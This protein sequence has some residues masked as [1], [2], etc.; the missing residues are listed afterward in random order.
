MQMP[1]DS[2]KSEADA[3]TERAAEV[4]FKQ[5]VFTSIGGGMIFALVGVV[6]TALLAPVVAGGFSFTALLGVGAVAAAGLSCAF[7]AAKYL[8]QAVSMDQDAQ[9]KKIGAVTRGKS[10]AFTPSINVEQTKPHSVPYGEE[11][12]ADK[13]H[14]KPLKDQPDTVVSHVALH[15]KMNAMDMPSRAIH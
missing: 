11:A 15:E 5:Q 6:A 9:A 10:P 2:L 13:A 1:H 8:S 3:L 4:R 14:E 12:T 7:M